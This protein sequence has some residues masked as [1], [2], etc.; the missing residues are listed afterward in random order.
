MTRPDTARTRLALDHQ[1]TPDALDAIAWNHRALIEFD[2]ARGVKVVT[3]DGV[4]WWA[5]LADEAVA[6][7]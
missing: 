1:L 4:A 5:E 6:S 2:S 3:L 7:S